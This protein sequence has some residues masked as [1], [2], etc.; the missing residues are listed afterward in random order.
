MFMPMQGDQ[1]GEGDWLVPYEG[2]GGIND[3]T[4]AIMIDADTGVIDEATWLDP[5]DNNGNP[6]TLPQL[7]LM[8]T[9]EASGL[10]PADN[11]VPEPVS[12]SLLIVTGAGLLG[13]RRK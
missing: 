11:S 1:S 5:T 4:G 3:V 6:L 10:E 12:M 13:R 9:D 7:D 2:S 8:F